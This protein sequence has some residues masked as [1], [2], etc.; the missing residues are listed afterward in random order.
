MVRLWALGVLAALALAACDK[1]PNQQA[2][3]AGPSVV[4]CAAG[5]DRAVSFTTPQAKDT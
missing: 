5:V 3:S 2:R 4:A 1:V